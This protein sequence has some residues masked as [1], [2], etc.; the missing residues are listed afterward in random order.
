MLFLF[1]IKSLKI[2]LYLDIFCE[3]DDYWIRG[4]NKC[5]QLVTKSLTV[6]DHGKAQSRKCKLLLLA[7]YMS[8]V[9][10]GRIIEFCSVASWCFLSFYFRV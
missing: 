10:L 5:L 9:P 6:I 2:L 1:Y 3:L 7:V 8:G 4:K